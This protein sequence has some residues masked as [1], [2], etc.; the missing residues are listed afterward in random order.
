MKDI[1]IPEGLK[2]KWTTY[3]SWELSIEVSTYVSEK[4]K[5]IV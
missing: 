4:K 5:R 3:P 2:A 1:L